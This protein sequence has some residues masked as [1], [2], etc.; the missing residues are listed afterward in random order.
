MTTLHGFV[1]SHIQ[2]IEMA[3]SV[4]FCSDFEKSVS[5]TDEGWYTKF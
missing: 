2:K 1:N 5:A 3:I 4:I